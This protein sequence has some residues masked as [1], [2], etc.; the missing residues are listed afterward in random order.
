MAEQY[1]ETPH[2]VVL[3]DG[4]YGEDVSINYIPEPDVGLP[5]PVLDGGRVFRLDGALA[6]QF[7]Q[8]H[9]RGGGDER[10]V[11]VVTTA[12]PGLFAL[13]DMAE[14]ARRAAEWRARKKKP[15]PGR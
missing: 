3:I 4:V 5:F 8:L 14:A 15:R 13:V 9:R 2:G 10:V 7:R 11:L 1:A 6:V 12:T